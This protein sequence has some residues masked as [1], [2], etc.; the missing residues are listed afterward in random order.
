[1]KAYLGEPRYEHNK[2]C[3]VQSVD[4]GVTTSIAHFLGIAMDTEWVRE[5]AS[6]CY[7]LLM[8]ILWREEHKRKSV[9]RAVRFGV[10]MSFLNLYAAEV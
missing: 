3:S 10:V 8:C 5:I 2:T 6:M 7:V 9:G 4:M 1:M